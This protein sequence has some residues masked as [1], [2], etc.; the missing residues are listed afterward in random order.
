MVRNVWY[1]SRVEGVAYD[2]PANRGIG[3][4]QSQTKGTLRFKGSALRSR[5][6]MHSNR[7]ISPI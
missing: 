2:L 7:P 5:G 1:L 4:C 3:G 6:S